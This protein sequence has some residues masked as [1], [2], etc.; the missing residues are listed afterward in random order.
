MIIH[1][2]ALTIHRV[3]G[4]NRIH[5]AVNTAWFVIGQGN[6]VLARGDEVS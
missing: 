6:M 4:V 5:T 2:M 3:V 1:R